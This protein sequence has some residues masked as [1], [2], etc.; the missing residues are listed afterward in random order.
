M[1]DIP[2]QIETKYLLKILDS[3]ESGMNIVDKNGTIMWVNQACCKLFNKNKEDLIG[4]NIFVLKKEGAFTP[5]VI[6]MALQN[7]STVTTVQEIIGGNKMTVTGDIILDEQENPIYFVAH[8]H[9]ISNWMDNISKLKWEELAPVLNRYLLEIKKM[10]TRYILIKDEQ[11]FIGHSKV[12]NLLAEILERV[13][14][15][16]S[17]VLINGETGVGKNVVAKRIHELSER[18][19]QPFV[20]LNC[21]A[22]PDTLLESELFGYH[23]G[24]FTGANSKGKTGLVKTAEKGTLFLD[25]ISELPLHLQPKLL[26]L[27]QDKTYMPIGG[28][29]LVKA[30]IRI[31]AAT[32]RKIEEMVKE[33]KFR[34]DLYYRLHVLPVNIPP[35]RERREDIFPLIHFYLQKYNQIFNQTRT[36]SKQTID[37]FQRYQWPGN[38]RELEN[39]IEQLVIMAKKEE[40]SIHDLPDRFHSVSM[41]E[42]ALESLKKGNNLSEIIENMEKTIIEQAI[43]ENKT[44]RKTA[45]VLGITQT[46]LIRRLKKYNIRNEKE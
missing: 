29:Q 18:N 25:E 39:T 20:H 46:S 38:I 6:E 3:L 34:A 43:K 4:R 45:K 28:S 23:K 31:I 37:V 36:F 30:D 17:T 33:G 27:L 21:A 22:I 13:A 42:E 40:I 19:S 7:G 15:V 2:V 5:S 24:A 14:N 32:N 8:G 11:S 16:H 41:A 9:D 26:Q 1:S 35:L 10:N 44:T 12:H